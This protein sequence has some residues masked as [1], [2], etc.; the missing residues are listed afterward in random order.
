[1]KFFHDKMVSKKKADMTPLQWQEY[2]NA[3]ISCCYAAPDDYPW[4]PINDNDGREKV[5]CKCLKTTCDFFKRCRP[6]FNPDEL[7]VLEENKKAQLVIFEFENVATQV[8]EQKDS[9]IPEQ[10]M[11][12]EEKPLVVRK[13]SVEPSSVISKKSAT[14]PKPAKVK[15]V[16]FDSF[17]ETTQENI[18]EAEPEERSI[19]NA[20]P[21][22]GKNWTL[23]EKIIYMLN[24][25]KGTLGILT[26]TNGHA[27][28]VSAW[29]H[30]EGVPHSLNRGMSASTLG[31]WIARIFY[32]CK[33]NTIDEK[34]FITLY[35]AHFPTKSND[36]A[37]NH[38]T[39]LTSTQRESKPRYEISDL[40]KGILKNARDPLL[41]ESE[42]NKECAITVSNIHRAKGKEFDSV[43]VLEDV[44]EN[45]TKLENGNILEHK[46]CYVALTR[47][48]GKI[49]RV[50][51]SDRD[52]QIYI[53]RNEDQSN[54]CS[55]ARIRKKKSIS[56]FEV[57]NDTD[58]DAKSFADD[59]NIQ[60]YIQKNI[61]SGMRLKLIKC[62]E[63]TKP[64][65]VYKIVLEEN[66]NT[67]LGYTSKS[68]AREL[69]KAM[70][71]IMEI[72]CSVYHSVYPNVFYKVY[73]HDIAT[74]LSTMA[75]VPA[76]AKIFG[77][78]SIW[79]GITITDFAKVYQDKY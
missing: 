60:H 54:R 71:H 64:Y 58:L 74:Y 77:D 41:Y 13:F 1:M 30:T 5:V 78:I 57:G 44:I 35:R 36:V 39:A 59:E 21:G 26:R 10:K 45:M 68:F 67:M 19:I 20:A 2:R 42:T 69:E 18:I 66:P 25:R 27:L 33:N 34:E 61:R 24:E 46:V 72:N 75:P 38:W 70:Q 55:K 50:Q 29:L 4:G 53:T 76:G 12:P 73:V 37:K 51:I 8:E 22:T 40:L 9:S 3:S 14:V 47:P 17:S 48:K 79:L 6:D 31:G 15:K 65:V 7:L 62:P 63:G 32:D 52:K 28:Q 16:G 11:L 43:I 23:I 49:E 56:H